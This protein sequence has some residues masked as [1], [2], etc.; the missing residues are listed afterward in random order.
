[1]RRGDRARQIA[2]VL[3]GA[4]GRLAAGDRVEAEQLTWM[5]RNAI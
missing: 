5:A 3:R 1:M 4:L 2:A